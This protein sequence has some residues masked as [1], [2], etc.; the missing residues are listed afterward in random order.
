[1]DREAINQARAY[2]AAY[3]QEP[4]TVWLKLALERIEQLEVFVV[5]WDEMLAGSKIMQG[6]VKSHPRGRALTAARA[7]VGEVRKP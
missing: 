1:M 4:Y 6:Y 7:A 5:A 2:C 3:P